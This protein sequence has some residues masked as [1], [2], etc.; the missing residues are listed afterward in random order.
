MFDINK[1]K[2]YLYMLTFVQYKICLKMCNSQ[3]K[4]TPRD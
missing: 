4:D 2:G 1:N 3:Y